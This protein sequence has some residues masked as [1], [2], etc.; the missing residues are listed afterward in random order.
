[1]VDSRQPGLVNIDHPLSVEEQGH[2]AGMPEDA[3][4][5][6]RLERFLAWLTPVVFGYALLYAAIGGL[7]GDLAT[8]VASTVIAA[9]G[10]LL[11]LA[12]LATSGQRTQA[13]ALIVAAGF[14]GAIV[15]LAGLQPALAP[16]HAMVPLLV[17]LLVLLYAPNP[18][19][20]TTIA[21]C[22]VIAAM[23]LLVGELSPVA[24]RLPATVETV[25]R[26]ATF[27]GNLVFALLLVGQL[28]Q[29]MLAV[30]RQIQ[31]GYHALSAAHREL[32]ARARLDPLTG[33]LHRGELE[34]VCADALAHAAQAGT[35]VGVILLD[36]DHFKAV[37]DTFGHA[38][39]DQVLREL[40]KLLRITLRSTDWA[41]RYGGEE[42]VLILPGIRLDAAVL[43]AQQIRRHVHALRLEHDGRALGALTISAGVALY[44]QH[45]TT[46]ADLVHAADMALYDAKR[47]G[48]DCVRVARTP[49][50]TR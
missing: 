36:I 12:R 11:L 34:G 38:A 10:V 6:M 26:L 24:S 41:C 43:R 35:S 19:Q 1:M 47:A 15:V 22:G 40:G 28:R 3:M 32:H 7:F 50:R 46:V 13:G 18:P 49:T 5:P 33:V 4:A 8:L 9:V 25:L 48:R 14:L 29:R 27:T 2:A 21:G 30:M 23:V 16:S 39:G 45:G 20:N 37:N 42:F 44:P 31:A 17:A